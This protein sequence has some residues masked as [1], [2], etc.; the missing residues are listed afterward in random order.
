MNFISAILLYPFYSHCT[1]LI[2]GKK[3]APSGALNSRGKLPTLLYRLHVNSL[4]R[5]VQPVIVHD[6]VDQGKQCEVPAHTDVSSRVNACAELAN[7]D[8]AC[9]DGFSAE[10]FDPAPLP[11]AIAPVSGASSSFLMCHFRFLF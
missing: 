9:T 2:A 8:I 7:D 6:A 4:A 3:K 11:L 5:S 1:M 10:D